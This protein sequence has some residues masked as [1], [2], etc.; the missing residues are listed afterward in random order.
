VITAKVVD[1]EGLRRQVDKWEADIRP[2]A[3]GFLGSTAG[4][5]DDGR[6]I[7]LARF[8]SEEVAQ[9]NSQR[10]EQ[11]E[12]WAETEKALA[13]VEF[14]NSVEVTTMGRGGSDDAGFVQVMRGRISDKEKMDELRS[15]M[16]EMED[17]MASHRPDVLGDVVAIH[18]DDSYT[19][20]VYFT[21]EAEA[22]AGEGKPPPPE[23]QALFEEFMS[24]FVV[25]DYLD[26]KDPWLR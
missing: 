10:A 18:D 24:A 22:R 9:R 13:D 26:L 15:R 23:A 2:G 25:D 14:K 8:E 12:W 5:T 16:M 4:I 17:A 6:F 11:G 3:T 19:D 20:A 7:V 1:A 21:S